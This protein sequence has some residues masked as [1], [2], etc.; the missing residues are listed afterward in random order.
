MGI[1]ISPAALNLARTNLKH[2]LKS[3][4]LDSRA[5]KD[6]QFCRADVLGLSGAG[7]D[8]PNVEDI[9]KEEYFQ[10]DGTAKI[11]CDLL[12]SNP[13]YISTK[14][15]RNGT[16]AKSVRLF[17]PK[18]ALVPDPQ[19]QPQP[20][21]YP[22]GTPSQKSKGE[23]LNVLPQD[24]FYRHILELS[25][26]LRTKLTVLE[27][28]DIEQAERV[29]ELHTAIAEHSEDAHYDVQIWPSSEADMQYYGFHPGQGSRCV[30]IQR[31][32]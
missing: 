8:A 12:I 17:E 7:A 14:D 11:Q 2:N 24:I 19:L 28:G 27:C 18:L 3:G 25:H 23:T 29:V 20:F 9:L 22:A 26:K 16:T 1:D 21:Q 5:E 31:N 4:L 10:S 6:I 30:I 13:P 15:F 32:C